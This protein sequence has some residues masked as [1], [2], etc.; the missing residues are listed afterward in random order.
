MHNF[1]LQIKSSVLDTYARLGGP[2]HLELGFGITITVQKH[3]F[4]NLQ[5][6]HTSELKCKLILGNIW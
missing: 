4:M 5:L 1:R 6:V 3:P 2:L